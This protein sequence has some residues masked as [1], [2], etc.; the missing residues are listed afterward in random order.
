[1]RINSRHI[2][3]LALLIL[4]SIG[5]GF[6]FDAIATAVDRHSYPLV[7]S[8]AEQVAQESERHGIEEPILWAV[9]CTSGGFVSNTVS[10]DGRIGLMQLSPEIFSFICTELWR[11]EAKDAGMLYD[12]TTNL[13][14]GCA[15]LAYLYTY[16]GVWEHAH[17]AYFAGVETVNAWLED[18]ENLTAQGVLE[19]IPDEKTAAYVEE[20]T[21]AADH[22]RQLYYQS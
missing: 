18:P 22:Y 6:A 2:A 11:G 20:V 8:L 15:Y 10:E 16:Y 5:F 1:M 12:P 7:E 17:A 14:A 21:K 3:I 4:L 13:S 9:L 19:S